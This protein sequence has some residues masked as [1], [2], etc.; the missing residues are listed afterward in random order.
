MATRPLPRLPREL[1]ERGVAASYIQ[2]WRYATAGR[3]PATLRGARWFYD[4]EDL[5]RIAAQFGAD[6]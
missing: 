2:C 5:P 6:Q 4:D 3:I 1:T